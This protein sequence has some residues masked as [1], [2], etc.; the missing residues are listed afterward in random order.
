MNLGEFLAEKL[1]IVLSAAVADDFTGFLTALHGGVKFLEDREVCLSENGSPLQGAM[2]GG[3]RAVL[4]H[5]V[6]A[7]LIDETDQALG[8]LL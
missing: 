3:G 2:L 8:Q 4:V 6:H 1:L 7:V 5:P